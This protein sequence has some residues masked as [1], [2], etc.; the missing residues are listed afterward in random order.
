MK[1]RFRGFTLIE[2]IVAMAILGIAS[3][4]IAQMYA[5]VST[6]NKMNH[7]VNSSLSNQ[8]AYVEKYTDSEAVS[9]TYSGTITTKP[10]HISNPSN[11]TNV[12]KIERT[13]NGD[14]YSFPVDVYVLKSRDRHDN[15]LGND[16]GYSEEDYNLRYKYV[17]GH[18]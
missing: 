14:L 11:N 18:N 2:C 5:A 10:P 9:I 6:R 16:S 8:M 7:L 4:I 17:L 13:D 15:Q 12:V 1:K 3:L